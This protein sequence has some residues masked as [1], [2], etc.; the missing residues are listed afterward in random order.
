MTEEELKKKEAELS[1]KELDLKKKEENIDKKETE[2]LKTI[3]EE[4]DK[5]ILDMK[6][7]HEEE[8]KKEQERNVQ[9]IKALMSGRQ[10]EIQENPVEELSF[11]D[12]A[13]IDTKKLLGLKE[14]N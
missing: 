9:Q 6:K 14:E 3:R 7:A 10:V 4:Y 5:Q 1:K 12:Q 2:V 13:L 11:E 8:M